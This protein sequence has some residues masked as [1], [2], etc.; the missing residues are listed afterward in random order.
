MSSTVLV[1]FPDD[2]KTAESTSFVAVKPMWNVVKL[3]ILLTNFV[4]PI[5]SNV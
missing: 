2:N 4:Y 5:L 1:Q 3:E